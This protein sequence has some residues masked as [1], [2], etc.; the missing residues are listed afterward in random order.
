MQQSLL[1]A[2]RTTDTGYGLEYAEYF[3][4]SQ[5]ER[6]GHTHLANTS[7]RVFN[8][9]KAPQ[10]EQGAEN[11]HRSEVRSK[12]QSAM[13]SKGHG[14]QDSVDPNFR[15]IS[16]YERGAVTDRRFDRPRREG[17]LPPRGRAG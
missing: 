7:H 15:P 9:Y 2:A 8:N 6:L 16:E 12:D 11:S 5:T 4:R 14:R 17:M 1:N 10:Q 13:Q 3:L